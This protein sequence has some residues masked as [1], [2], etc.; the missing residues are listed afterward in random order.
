[1]SARELA[2]RGIRVLLVDRNSFPR[3]KVCGACLN[4]RAVS[5]L[6]RA[7]LNELLPRLGAIPTR[8]FRASCGGRSLEINLSGGA[9]VSR[10]ALDNA[11]IQAAQAAGAEFLSETT[12]KLCPSDADS[13]DR[14]IELSG[15]S[16]ARR[17]ARARIVLIACGLGHSVFSGMCEFSEQVAPHARIGVG[18][19]VADGAGVCP[20]TIYM[21]VGRGGYVGMVRVEDGSINL[22]AA[23]DPEALKRAGSPAAVVAAILREFDGDGAT[24]AAAGNWRGTLPLTRCLTRV[25]SHRGFV[26][27]DAAGYV[28]PFTGEGIGWALESGAAIAPLVERSLTAWSAARETEWIQLH[29]RIVGQRQLWC[30]GFAALLRHPRLAQL[31][32]RAAA[33]WP[34]LCQSIVNS[35]NRPS[36]TQEA[37]HS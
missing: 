19:R 27:G 10:D 1:M 16:G 5:C 36:R 33:V 35:I 15:P 8:R 6:E 12:A 22:A 25:A 20:G 29:R 4:Q 37:W 2:R 13:S 26:L 3:P 34:G 17:T 9:A 18:A 32:I 14:E 31:A 30:R 7:G 21:A 24:A 28:E 23:L 11:L